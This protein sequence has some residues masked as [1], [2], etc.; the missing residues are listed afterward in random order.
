MV[1][2]KT[3][4]AIWAALGLILT[5][6]SAVPGV[7]GDAQNELDSRPVNGDAEASALDG[8]D[9]SVADVQT[10]DQ[11]AV[12]ADQ[13]GPG[14]VIVAEFEEST[15]GFEPPPGPNPRCGTVTV[16]AD[17][18]AVDPSG[19]VP[20]GED[21]I[22]LAVAVLPSTSGSPADDPIVYL[23]GGPGSHSLETSRFFVDFLEPMR[24]RG[25]VVLFDQR[26]VGLTTPRLHCPESQAIQRQLEDDP[27]IDDDQASDLFDGALGQCADRLLSSGIDL[28]DYSTVNSSHDVEAIRIALG[29]DQWNLVG[30]SYGTR[31]GLEVLRRHPEMVR[32]AV[33]DSVLPPEVEPV[34]DNPQTFV[35]S[36]ELVVAACAAEPACAGGGDLSQRLRS[37]VDRY[38]QDPVQI[39]IENWITGESDEIYLTGDEII[40][41]AVQALYSPS[42]F[43]DLPELVA[44]LEEG[45]TGAAVEFL[46][47]DRSTEQFFSNAMFYS[48]VCQEEVAFADPDEVAAALPVNPFD[49]DGE[50]FDFASN[51][52]SRAFETCEAFG[53]GVLLESQEADGSTAPVASDVP[54]LLLGGRFDPV[55]PASW[56]QVAAQSLSAAQV[57]VA[58][59]LSHGV[60]SDPCGL[61]VVVSFIE[62][63]NDAVDP[64]CLDN[65]DLRFLGP[66]EAEVEL[67]EAEIVGPSGGSLQ[68]LQPSE[69]SKG[70]LEGDQ[71]RRDSFLDPTELFQLIGNPSLI[72]VIQDFIE[73]GQGFQLPPAS[74]FAGDE[75][76]G[77][78]GPDDLDQNWSRRTATGGGVIVEW[79]EVDVDQRRVV[80]ALVAPEA[81]Y[82]VLVAS[83]LEPALRAIE[84]S[85]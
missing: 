57:V 12:G 19:V 41:I 72:T 8:S 50:P 29:F 62:Q 31:L 68:I 32:S 60:S 49:V 20:E 74:P 2:S 34:R 78:L 16:P 28:T 25:D 64:S 26:G 55:T 46:S 52:G 7:G 85:S 58:P 82:D 77:S 14:P 15:C 43:G 75:R 24:E 40:G 1:G 53:D 11:E 23:D 33:L 63:P 4:W 48:L 70:S 9:D 27:S 47:Q 22:E 84:I 71:Y 30:V 17:W 44:E 67:E 42:Q 13:L 36:Y 10:N 69:W 73:E 21:T 5:A 54:T 81:E 80:V 18:S 76:L 79:F 61:R 83:V 3:G 38:D 56:A 6:C 37:V 45:R 35:D 59:E 65:T 66:P 39:E 51:V